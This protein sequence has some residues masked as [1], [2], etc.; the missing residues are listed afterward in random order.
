M[1]S[2]FKRIVH[3]PNVLALS[4]VSFFND[5]SSEMIYPLLPLFI[6]GVLGAGASAVGAIEG[7]AEA[8]LSLSN[9]L[10]GSISDRIK[11]KKPFILTGYL[12]ANVAR[13]L[14]G[15]T[16]HWWQIMGLRTADRLGKGIR[17]PPRDGLIAS[18]APL[19]DR[20]AAFGFQRGM[21]NT[22]AFIGPLL[23][24]LFLLH[25]HSLRTLFLTAAIP[26]IVTVLVV[27][28]CVRETRPSKTAPLPPLARGPKRVS[29]SK[30][31]TF[32]RDVILYLTALA[33]FSLGNSSDAFLMLKA[34]ELGFATATIPLLWMVLHASRALLSFPGGLSADRWGRKGVLL[35]GWAVYGGVYS[36]LA[37]TTS[38]TVLWFLLPLYGLYYGLTEGAERALLSELVPSHAMGRGFGWF[39]GVK[40]LAL[41]S[42]NLI[43]GYLWQR[44]GA[45]IA[46]AEGALC[47]V[48]AVPLLLKVRRDNT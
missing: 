40:G 16:S 6:T 5:V 10:S 39:H 2:P 9:V 22:G 33:L 45:G 12:I 4:V 7:V 11:R 13:P 21:D 17:T 31:E 29:L 42:G 36:A 37:V 3:Y 46:F 24:F 43:F 35:A 25:W 15:I 23:A 28:L 14:M 26:G 30:R 47:A 20:G 19:G 34:G 38:P 32:N 44:W 18:S 41:L 48:L 27:I 1:S 8:I